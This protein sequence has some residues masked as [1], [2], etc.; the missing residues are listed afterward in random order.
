MCLM[1]FH[2]WLIS[3]QFNLIVPI[4]QDISYMNYE[5]TRD[6]LYLFLV[7]L[8]RRIDPTT[9]FEAMTGIVNGLCSSMI[10]LG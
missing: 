6:L 9:S 1:Q 2:V 5:Y 10:C 8:D 3:C 7:F 4:I